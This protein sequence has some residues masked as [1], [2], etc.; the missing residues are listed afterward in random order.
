MRPGMEFK[1]DYFF[2]LVSGLDADAGQIP[3]H[4][5][6][7]VRMA[8]PISFPLQKL[9][10]LPVIQVETAIENARDDDLAALANDREIARKIL[11]EDLDGM[12]GRHA[13]RHRISD[14]HR[15]RRARADR[16]DEPW[17]TEL[18]VDEDRSSSPC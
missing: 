16:P 5:I 12:F 15:Q 18:F 8:H 10:N 1:G 4:R 7:E 11:M 17:R 3:V 13:G 14:D 6:K 9:E 2:L